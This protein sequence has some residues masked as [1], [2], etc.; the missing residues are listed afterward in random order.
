MTSFLRETMAK[1]GC[2]RKTE[3]GKRFF[4]F[5]FVV[6]VIE[7]NPKET[8]DSF[9]VGYVYVKKRKLCMCMCVCNIYKKKKKFFGGFFV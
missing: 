5:F 6:V 4:F 8:F 7:I 2:R 9:S 1:F 3:I